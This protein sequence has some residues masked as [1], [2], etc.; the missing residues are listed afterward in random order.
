MNEQILTSLSIITSFHDKNK[1]VVDSLLP[2][3]EYA[4]RGCSALTSVT[5]PDSVTSIGSYGI[6]C[7]Y[8]KIW[9]IIVLIIG[10]LAYSIVGILFSFGLIN[11]KNAGKAAQAFVFIIL[12]LLGYCIY[13]GIVTIQNWIINWP[14]SVKIIVPSLLLVVIIIILFYLLKKHR[15][16]NENCENT[17]LND[18]GEENE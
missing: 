3:V 18:M 2:L 11:G 12:L 13:C 4:F 9:N 6:S 7:L 14:L 5:I 10:M 1:S 8:D 16:K 15:E 17:N